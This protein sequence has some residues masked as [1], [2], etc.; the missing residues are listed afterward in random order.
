M[1]KVF[2]M[3]SKTNVWCWDVCDIWVELLDL[4]VKLKKRQSFE[5]RVWAVEKKSKH[6]EIA[7]SES[8][9]KTNMTAHLTCPQASDLRISC[10]ALQ[11]FSCTSNSFMRTS[12]S[13][14]LHWNAP[15]VVWTRRAAANQSVGFCLAQG[16]CMFTHHGESKK[17]HSLFT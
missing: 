2:A 1:A 15:A 9:K 3:Y 10:A 16:R 8:K 12:Y 6:R 11:C 14:W 17:I 5:K 7:P 13:V 4:C